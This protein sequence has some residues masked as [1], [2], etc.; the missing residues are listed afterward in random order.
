MSSLQL[1]I[2]KLPSTVVVQRAGVSGLAGLLQQPECDIVSCIPQTTSIMPQWRLYEPTLFGDRVGRAAQEA[3]TLAAILQQLEPC[4]RRKLEVHLQVRSSQ[5]VTQRLCPH[6]LFLQSN[7]SQLREHELLTDTITTLSPLSN[8]RTFAFCLPR[9]PHGQRPYRDAV[10]LLPSLQCLQIYF[11]T[12]TSVDHIHTFLHVLRDLPRVTSLRVVTN[13]I[14]LCLPSKFLQNMLTLE[15]GKQVRIGPLFSSLRH[16][17]LERLDL[18][19]LGYKEMFFGLQDMVDSMTL[20]SSFD[21]VALAALPIS[22]QKLYLK[23]S[24]ASY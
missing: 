4:T 15:L 8:L 16:L 3:R 10:R 13:E 21:V 11:T 9:N 12:K 20:H 6:L 2:T 14:A 1:I 23:Q 17:E 22:L 19:C 24:I 5:V 7:I 18:G